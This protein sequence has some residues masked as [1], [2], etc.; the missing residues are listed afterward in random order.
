MGW[1]DERVELLKKLWSDGLSASQIAAEL[2][3][4]TRNAVIGK[5]HRL[6]LQS[7][8]SP[9]KS[10]DAAKTAAPAPKPAAPEPAPAVAA[11]PPPAP[12]PT[13]VPPPEPKPEPVA[14]GHVV[15]GEGA[16]G[17]A[18]AA[19]KKDDPNPAALTVGD[20]VRVAGEI[21]D[22]AIALAVGKAA[23]G[24]NVLP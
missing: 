7:R 6:G 14:A 17:R 23:A 1:T 5:A 18:A 8:P 22:P 13:P 12:K 9:V 2:G 20:L 21:K 24:C 3:G 11:P 15:V 10:N 4:I 19:Y 16:L